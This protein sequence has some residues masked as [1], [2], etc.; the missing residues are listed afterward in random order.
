MQEPAEQQLPKISTG[1]I[2]DNSFIPIPH[3]RE[4]RRPEVVFVNETNPLNPYTRHGEL[5]RFFDFS[6]DNAVSLA[7]ASGEGFHHDEAR[8]R[9]VGEAFSRI[10]SL[11]SR[12]AVLEV[13]PGTNT[14]IAEGVSS[15]AHVPISLL[16]SKDG[17]PGTVT[18]GNSTNGMR[19]YGGSISD[20]SSPSSDLRDERF[21]TIMFNGSW[22][23]GGY[24]FT[25][26]DNLSLEYQQRN[27]VPVLNPN[28]SEYQNFQNEQIDKILQSTKEHLTDNG[29]LIFSS[30]RYAFHGAGY[31]FTLL[32]VEKLEFLDI[33][34]RAQNLGAKKVTVVGVSTE[35]IEQMLQANLTETEMQAIREEQVSRKF[36]IGKSITR[37]PEYT[38]A[39]KDGTKLTFEE[40]QVFC[41][42]PD[43]RAALL[44]NSPDFAKLISERLQEYEQAGKEVIRQLTGGVDALPNSADYPTLT[45]DEIRTVKHQ[46]NGVIPRDIARIDA[47]GIEF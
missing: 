9:E 39:K 24:N 30:A 21:G 16:D 4:I 36:F 27:Q 25:V 28:S 47:I 12:G 7:P 1:E 23:A 35:G 40:L 2:K 13:G 46:T 26:K 14:F 43:K 42:D 6:G 37:G 44:K 41:K 19:N 33:I 22:V 45:P 3:E 5:N 20:I 15:S 10:F 11:G 18:G 32:P 38:L 29:V 31:S 34:A 17:T 8:Q